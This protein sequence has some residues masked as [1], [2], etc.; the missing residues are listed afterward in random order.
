[1]YASIL[2][3]EYDCTTCT[4]RQ[5]VLRGCEN[6]AERPVEM[7][8]EKLLRCPKRPLLDKPKELGEI[9]WLYR[10]YERGILPEEGSLLSQPNRL[11]TLLAALESA[12]SRAE[13]EQMEDMARKRPKGNVIVG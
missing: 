6:E 11:M 12:K 8:G 9:F 10:N 4:A 5:K 7:D 13:A 3:R 2:L 1:M